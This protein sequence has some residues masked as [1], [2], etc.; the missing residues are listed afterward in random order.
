MIIDPAFLGDVVFDVERRTIRHDFFESGVAALAIE[1]SPDGRHFVTSGTNGRIYVWNLSDRSRAAL[2]ESGRGDANALL[3]SPDGRHLIAGH[4]ARQVVFWGVPAPGAEPVAPRERRITE[5][6]RPPKSDR[7]ELITLFS[8]K[9]HLRNPSANQHEQ[10]WKTSG[11]VA[12][13]ECAKDDPCFVTRYDGKFEAVARI[14]RDSQGKYVLLIGSAASERVNEGGDQTGAAYIYGYA[15]PRS[16]Q[17]ARGQ[18]YSART[19]KTDTREKDRWTTIWGVF[20]VGK[21]IWK[22]NFEIRQAD[23]HHP[24]D[25]SASR[26]DDLGVYL[27][28][29]REGAESFVGRYERAT[30][31]ASDAA[32]ASPAETPAAAAPAQEG[33]VA[34]EIGGRLSFVLESDCARRSSAEH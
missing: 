8:K 23:G 33:M 19:L 18:H 5:L 28:D 17:S 7:A 9:N 16:Y 4:E 26:F 10:F 2:I 29:T 12:I 3:F 25:G 30:S 6:P 31:R 34:C 15:E 14:P 22:I 27:F 24:K 13:E 32:D 1:F 20:E 11:D 21:D